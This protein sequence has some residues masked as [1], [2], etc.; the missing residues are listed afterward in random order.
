MQA[1]RKPFET[2]EIGSLSKPAWRVKAYRGEPASEA[3]LAEARAWGERLGIEG[4]GALLEALRAPD[5][6]ERRRAALEWSAVYAIRLLE[7]AGLDVVFDG[8]Q[9]RREMYEH[10]IASIEG[11]AFLGEV[12]SFDNKYYRKAACIDRPKRAKPI[13]LEEFLF[14]KS[15]AHRPLKVPVT[16]AYTLADW[17]F[18]EYYRRAWKAKAKGLRAQREGAKRDLVLDLAREVLRPELRD[19]ASAGAEWIQIDEPAA[20]THPGEWEME[21][22]AEAFRESASGLPCRVSL[23][24]CYSDY[25]LL[26]KWAPELRGC[27]QIS[28]EFANRDSRRL[29]TSESDRPGYWALRAFEEAGYEG[30]YGLGV[31]DVHTDF[32]EPPELV[33]DRILYALRTIGGDP[34]RIQPCPDCG[35]RTRSWDVALAKLRALVEGARMAREEVE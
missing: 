15:K 4:H 19:L 26:A 25:G 27:C 20:T 21:L 3:D 23:H 13:Y 1:L 9:W 33:R 2:M 14:A 18:D 28:L 29:G 10:A 6:P 11:F 24:N 16:G 34:R 22:F 8:E 32:I 35:L 31:I 7:S 17:S 5:S 12:R 30:S